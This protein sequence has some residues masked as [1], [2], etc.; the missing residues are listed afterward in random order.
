MTEFVQTQSIYKYNTA[1]EVSQEMI[2]KL[3]PGNPCN[4]ALVSFSREE[5]FK[6]GLSESEITLQCRKTRLLLKNIF[7]LLHET[8]GFDRDGNY[9]LVKCRPLNNGGCRFLIEF[10]DQP[11]GRLFY[12]HQ[13]DDLL[14][15][16]NR[17]SGEIVPALEITRSGDAY[18]IY[19]PSG[20]GLTER[21]LAVL[22]E[23]A[24]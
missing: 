13:A 24:M 3:L 5:F 17:L 7:A 21:E 6:L 11:S 23:Y 14:D 20:A 22:N 12:F 16:V 15:A 1:S 2:I 10:T 9:V 19:I 8:A 4:A 18:Q